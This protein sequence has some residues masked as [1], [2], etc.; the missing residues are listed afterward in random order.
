MT[1]LLF[2]PNGTGRF[3]HSDEA[4]DVARAVG[5]ITVR[6]ASHVEPTPDGR[7]AADMSPVRL[8]VTLG[9]YDTRREA[10][11]AEREWLES[12]DVPIPREE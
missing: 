4:A 5:S 1:V 3:I 6:R 9:P 7:W 11:D 2:A 8:G 12:N 10:L